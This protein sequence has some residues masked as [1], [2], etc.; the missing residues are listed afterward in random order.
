MLLYANLPNSADTT[1]VTA[2]LRAFAE[3]RDFVVPDGA[4]I[5]DT[6][7]RARSRRERPGWF[8]ASRLLR[9]NSVEGV[10]APAITHIASTQGDQ[11]EFRA[12]LASIAKFANYLDEPDKDAPSAVEVTRADA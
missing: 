3:A 2:S 11:A 9:E 7:P 1:R 4:V 6:A 12:W 8:E 5:I 10:I